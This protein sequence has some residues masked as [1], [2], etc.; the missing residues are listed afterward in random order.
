MWHLAAATGL[1]RIELQAILERLRLRESRRRGRRWSQP[2]SRR[3]LVVCVTLRTNLTVRELAAVFAISKS[4]AHRIVTDLVPK[5]AILLPS[6]VDADRRWTWILDGTLVPTRDHWAA[7][8]SKNYRWSCNAQL[9]VRRDDRSVI[10][11]AAGGPG[12]RNDRIHY[13]GS[14]I[15]AMCQQHRRVL[16]DGGYRGIAELVTPRFRANRIVR[17]AAWTRHRDR[18]APVEHTIARLKDWRVLRDH[19]RRGRH[20]PHTIGA[21]AFLYNLCLKMRDIS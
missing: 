13:R 2:L 21:V 17:D 8:K 5:I 7:A 15:E 1:T 14:V 6:T 9:L 12:N 11:V 18:R 19:R 4:Q 3:L 16:A 10:A 20:L